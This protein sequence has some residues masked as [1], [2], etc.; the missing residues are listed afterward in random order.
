R[1]RH[2]GACIHC[3]TTA[4]TAQR[5]PQADAECQFFNGDHQSLRVENRY[6]RPDCG[7]RGSGPHSGQAGSV[8]E[9][10]LRDR[11]LFAQ[12]WR[13][14]G[15]LRSDGAQLPGHE[16]Y[17]TGHA[18]ACAGQRRSEL[19]IFRKVMS[20]MNIPTL[21][22]PKERFD[23]LRQLLYPAQRTQS[24]TLH[25]VL[26]LDEPARDAAFDMGPDHFIGIQLRRVGGKKNR[27]SR[28]CVLSTN[29][30][31]TVAR[32]CLSSDS[33]GKTTHTEATG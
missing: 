12:T 20:G 19:L 6:R 28:P 4:E 16:R 27:R 31:T 18:L 13:A 25:F 15:A 7:Y 5:A 29:V 9:R 22:L 1:T 2:A 21:G 32:P 17:D 11:S 8:S 10:V 30:L 24:E 14:A 26:A 3:A 33:V 23:Q